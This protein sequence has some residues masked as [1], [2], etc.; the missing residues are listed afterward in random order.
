VVADL[1]EDGQR[2]DPHPAR[3]FQQGFAEPVDG[4]ASTVEGVGDQ[5]VVSADRGEVVEQVPVVAG[6]FDVDAFDDP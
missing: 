4:H 1:V 2:V 3:T 5:R 6:A